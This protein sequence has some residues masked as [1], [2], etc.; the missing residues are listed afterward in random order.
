MLNDAAGIIE[1]K[2]FI[3]EWQIRD[4]TAAKRKISLPLTERPE[5]AL[6]KVESDDASTAGGVIREILPES[7]TAFEH[8]TSFLR[9]FF[10]KR[11]ERINRTKTKRLLKIPDIPVFF[12]EIR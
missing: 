4:I 7:A 9:I 8:Q 6:R 11:P 12:P 2:S 10:E 5:R 3:G 1:I